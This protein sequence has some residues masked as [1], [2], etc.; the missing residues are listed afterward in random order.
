MPR[1][2]SLL[3]SVE[4]EQLLPHPGVDSRVAPS[5][6]CLPVEP[7]FPPGSRR[8]VGATIASASLEPAWSSKGQLWDI[9]WLIVWFALPDGWTR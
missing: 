4:A 7:E 8:D 5:P 6:P 1:S 3:A 2:D 9:D